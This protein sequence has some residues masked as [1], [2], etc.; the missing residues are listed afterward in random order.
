MR[1]F[2]CTVRSTDFQLD[3][4]IFPL[5]FSIL[6]CAK[7]RGMKRRKVF[8]GTSFVCTKMVF[9]HPMNLQ[10]ILTIKMQNAMLP[11]HQYQLICGA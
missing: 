9:Y 11:I 8:S 10:K 3:N 5:L 1:I 7:A 4:V 2:E 6:E